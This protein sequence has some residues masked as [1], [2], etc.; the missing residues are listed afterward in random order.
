MNLLPLFRRELIE[1]GSRKRTFASRTAFAILFSGVILTMWSFYTRWGGF[2]STVL[3][4]GRELHFVIVWLELLTVALL[5]PLV[6]VSTF[7][8]E[9]ER[10]SY[11]LLRLTRLTSVELILETFLVRVVHVL[12]VLLLLLPM[13]ATAYSLGGVTTDELWA[14]WYVVS[15]FALQIGALAMLFASRVARPVAAYIAVISTLAAI[16]FL[17]PWL[18]FAFP[19]L[20]RTLPW[21]F[22][23]S[24][25]ALPWVPF[26]YLDGL[27][28]SGATS[29]AA[30]L[31]AS[32]P[33]WIPI[34]AFLSVAALV[35][36]RSAER[37]RRAGR[38]RRKAVPTGGRALA[39]ARRDVPPN[40]PI[41]WRERRRARSIRRK[42]MLLIWP[43]V[44]IVTIVIYV[45]SG[46]GSRVDELAALA[47]CCWAV[48]IL[49]MIVLGVNVIVSERTDQTLDTL[50][51]TPI[52]S[53]RILAEKCRGLVPAALTFAAPIVALLALA[54]TEE[55]T[56][57]RV[58]PI[59][60]LLFGLFT[61]ALFTPL[62]VL[63]GVRAGL[64][65]KRKMRAIGG[66]IVALIGWV[67]TPF[68][69]VACG[70]GGGEGMMYG[71]VLSPAVP[72]VAA[73][74]GAPD[75]DRGFVGVFVVTAVFY[76]CVLITLLALVR[77]DLGK[78]LGRAD[79]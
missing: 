54:A 46:P 33:V 53:E 32:W 45:Q 57:R 69:C 67:V 9:R 14:S 25:D 5:M 8:S 63:L 64:R 58:E 40:R 72:P 61:V 76:G 30:V 34:V 13:R 77:A 23:Q 48:H 37:A 66:S 56:Y 29:F 39:V 6:M 52:E 70:G 1:I 18:S 47:M 62:F 68:L 17:V 44:A 10:G 2:M 12:A 42:A 7:P 28:A 50:L 59:T 51:T 24:W 38:W 16:A 75:G 22:A 35:L 74:V 79:G 60:S 71:F 49:A 4:R 15:I 73:F 27:G 3:G 43:L 20:P 19:G 41:A 36:P 55:A 21:L 65:A 78:A 31:R 11:E 26:A